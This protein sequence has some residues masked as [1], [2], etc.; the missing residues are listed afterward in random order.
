MPVAN[1][2]MPASHQARLS[3]DLGASVAEGEGS[4]ERGPGHHFGDHRPSLRPRRSISHEVLGGTLQLLDLIAVVTAG[5]AAYAVYVI[6]LVGDQTGH[7]RYGLVI[8]IAACLFVLAQRRLGAY[9]VQSLSQLGWQLGRLALVWTAT[10]SALTTMAFIAKVAPY[11]SRGWAVTWVLLAFCELALLRI[12]ARYLVGWW[13]KRGLLSRAVVVVGAGKIGDQLVNKLATAAGADIVVAGIF[14]D[15]LTRVPSAIAGHRVLGTTDDLIVFARSFPIDEV[16]IALPLR[17]EERIA[18]LVQKLQTLPVDLR[19]SIDSIG[20]AF[21]MRRIGEIATAR[22]IDIVDRPLKHW[23]GVTKWVEDKVLGLAFLVLFAPLFALVALAIRL[24]SRGPVFFVQERFG[25]NNR[26][27]RVWKFRTMHVEV[28]DVSGSNRTVPSD[29]RV[30]R[31]GRFLRGM[32]L[33][34]LPQL[35]NV[36]IGDMSLV[37]P[38]PHVMA[39]KAGDRLYHDAVADYFLRHRVKPG[40]TGWAQVNGLRGE[41]DTVEKARRRIDHD[42]YY[43]G[44]WSLWLD[45]K[46]LLSTVRVLMSR[47]NAY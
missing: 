23:S 45:I 29:P 15:R 46:I 22:T 16:I 44:H 10:I 12:G 33:D 20:G 1:E 41:I 32:S 34:E 14:D 40:M 8:A 30:T 2:I 26:T 47:Q 13:A 25:F 38:R 37:G 4:A 6:V 3:S 5:I 28:S 7:D 27:F 17:A 31:V 43:I 24:D 18:E 35:L 19:L 9:T 42:L 39:M 36:L 11:Y 21:P